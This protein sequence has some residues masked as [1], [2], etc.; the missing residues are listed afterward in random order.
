MNSQQINW[1]KSIPVA[2]RGLHSAEE[3]IIENSKKAFE[4][5]IRHGYAIELD[6]QVIA[7]GEV[8]V[9][10]DY[11][12]ERVCGINEDVSELRTSDLTRFPF[13]GSTEN[14]PLLKDVLAFVN[15][16]VPLLIEIK[17]QSG[18][19]HA[20]M[21]ILNSLLGYKGAFAIQS[22]DP[23]ILGWFAKN[24]PLICRGQ[25]SS[26]FKDI[27]MNRLL[28]YLLKTFK[29]NFIS[30]PNFLAYNITDMP[31]RVIDRKRR[32]GLPVIVWTVTSETEQARIS[33]FCDNIIFELFQPK[34]TDTE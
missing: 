26:D 31:N 3:Q 25:L 8:V 18:V 1:L 10:H 9:F 11:N 4:N 22:F 23:F 24:A 27:P 12:L 6:A 16:Q 13:K 33:P 19:R 34:I 20:N 15:G 28:K 14:I 17:K 21:I 30:K 32:Q 5:A 29:F 2:H 7:D